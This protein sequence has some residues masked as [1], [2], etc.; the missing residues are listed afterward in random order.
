[1]CDLLYLID[2]Y[3]L[4]ADQNTLQKPQLSKL[5]VS[6][7]LMDQRLTH[8]V[9]LVLIFFCHIPVFVRRVI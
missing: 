1:M 3:Q 9:Q 8:D 2:A 5:V 4:C 7:G 6:N